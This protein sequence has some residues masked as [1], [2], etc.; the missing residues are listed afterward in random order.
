MFQGVSAV[1]R[2]K[3]WTISEVIAEALDRYLPTVTDDYKP[4]R[5]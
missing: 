5:P 2:A 3:N 1:C 4:V